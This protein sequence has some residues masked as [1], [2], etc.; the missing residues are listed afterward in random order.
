MTTLRAIAVGMW[1]GWNRYKPDRM[2]SSLAFLGMF[3]FVPLLYIALV[4]AGIFLN[5]EQ[6]LQQVG[7]AFG[8]TLGPDTTAFI[9]RML[10]TT[11]QQRT[12]S[13]VVISVINFGILLW[14][15]SGLFTT[16]EDQLNTI[17]GNPFP[18]ERPYLAVIRTQL[19]A[20]LFVL[21]LG[22]V[23]V[24]LTVGSFAFDLLAAWFQLP[25][26]AQV[27]NALLPTL[28]TIVCF[29]LTYRI[30]ARVKPRWR[31]IWLGALFAGVLLSVGRWLFSFY[32]LLTNFGSLFAAASTLAVLLLG[33][34]WAALIYLLGALLIGV[35]GKRAT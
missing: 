13:S 30:L 19:L 15:A 5:D 4:V 14:A 25:N 3:S 10:A 17:W 16:L 1:N 11:A 33:I 20:F 2:A 29:G 32:L 9:Q 23:F 18:T 7:R 24:V 26:A 34:Y 22:L 8:Q 12:T 21:A 28:V 31:D 6:V 35:L 27:A